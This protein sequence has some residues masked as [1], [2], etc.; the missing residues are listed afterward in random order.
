VAADGYPMVMPD[1]FFG[2]FEDNVITVGKVFFFSLDFEH[3]LQV[4]DRTP[5]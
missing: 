2:V 1:L 4:G 3:H 5:N